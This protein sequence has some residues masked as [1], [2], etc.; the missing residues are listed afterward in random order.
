MKMGILIPE[1]SKSI[2][3]LCCACILHFFVL[4]RSHKLEE[5]EKWKTDKN[6]KFLI[7]LVAFHFTQ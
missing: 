5:N 1:N 4:V 7:E 2:T 3:N 6:L